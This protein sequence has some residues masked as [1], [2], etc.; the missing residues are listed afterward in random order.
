MLLLLLLFLF[1]FFFLEYLV[2]KIV[3]TRVFEHNNRKITNEVQNKYFFMTIIIVAEA[4][5]K[6]VLEF[7]KKG[8]NDVELL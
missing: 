1:L 5:C 8:S 2:A 6:K 4:I 7:S 3:L